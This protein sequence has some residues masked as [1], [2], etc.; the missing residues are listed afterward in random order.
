YADLNSEIKVFHNATYK[1]H[2]GTEAAFSMYEKILIQF[3]KHIGKDVEKILSSL[4]VIQDAVKE[5]PSLP[6]TVCKQQH[7]LSLKGQQ[8]LGKNVTHAATEEPPSQTEGEN[9][10][11]ETQKT[12]E[13]KARKEKK[14][15]RLT[16]AVPVSTVR[17]LMR[18]NPEVEMMTSPA[19]VKLTDTVFV[20]PSFKPDTAATTLTIATNDDEPPKKLIKA[21]NIMRQDLDEPIQIPYEI[22]RKIYNLTNDE[23][24]EYLNKEEDIK[25]AAE[26]AKLL[27]MTKSELIKVVH[28]E[29]EKAG[30]DLKTLKSSKG[31]QEFKKI[32]D[33]EHARLRKIHEELEIQSALPV[34]APEQASCHLSGRKRTRLKIEHEIC[35][36]VL[37]CNMSLPEGVPFVNNMVIEKP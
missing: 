11:M 3:S 30:I 21:S 18:T 22:H 27:E 10:D 37:D 2:K 15:E 5:D 32:H 1:V 34:P 24:Q 26:E 8:L 33:P 19:T 6:Q 9:D 17:H 28:E 12:K 29:A 13:D 7:L 20:I 35:I 31:G 16:R 23:I 4:K 25:K 36:H 14:P